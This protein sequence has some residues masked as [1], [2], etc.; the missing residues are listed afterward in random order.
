MSFRRLKINRTHEG[1]PCNWCG[2]ELKLGDDAALCESCN[3]PHHAEC[4]QKNDG[5]GTDGCLNAPF[6]KVD[7]PASVLELQQQLKPDERVCQNCRRIT[8]AGDETCRH[9]HL[10][11]S[12]VP[13][14]GPKTR[15]PEA[16]EAFKYAL[17]GIFCCG[18]LFPVAIV[19]GTSAKAIIDADPRLSGRGLATAAQIIGIIGT[20]LLVINI[21]SLMAGKR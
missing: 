17:A 9:C 21:L 19:K 13:N 8:Y 3:L 7:T 2:Y 12:G 6:K 18:F 16:S 4:W 20:L 11:L 1:R 15:A 14:F 5:C 10:T